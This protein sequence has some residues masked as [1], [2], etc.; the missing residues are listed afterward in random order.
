MS[1]INN[2]KNTISPP[3]TEEQM[4]EKEMMKAYGLKKDPVVPHRYWIDDQRAINFNPGSLVSCQK[5][6]AKLDEMFN[7]PEIT[8]MQEDQK[9]RGPYGPKG[10]KQGEG[11]FAK[12]EPA[13][14]SVSEGTDREFREEFAAVNPKAIE[15][16]LLSTGGA[17]YEPVDYK[18]FLGDGAPK[19]KKKGK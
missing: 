14:R 1:I 13:I 11:F 10:Q 2:I 3:P 4:R 17:N 9:E 19:K 16:E 12:L 18:D 15:R 7:N 8:E 6:R 5:A